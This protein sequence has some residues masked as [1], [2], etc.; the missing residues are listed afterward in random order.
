MHSYIKTFSIT[1]IA[2]PFRFDSIKDKIYMYMSQ[3][4]IEDKDKD[5]FADKIFDVMQFYGKLVGEN[6]NGLLPAFVD[7]LI[8]YFQDLYYSDNA[9]S[10]I[11]I[12]ALSGV[13]SI[14]MRYKYTNS[15]IKK[16]IKLAKK[17]ISLLDNPQKVFLKGG[18][19][20]DIIGVEFVCSSPYEREWVARALYSFFYYQNRTDDHLVYGFYTLKRES[21]YKGLHCD[22]SIFYPR[23]DSR[24]QNTTKADISSFDTSMSHIDIL[25]NYFGL[26][27]IE[28]QIHTSFESLWS[29]MEH[30]YSYNI[31]AKGTGRDEK[32]RTQWKL[33][34]NSIES[35]EMQF[36]RLQVETQ[37]AQYQK[38]P[39]QG[40]KFAKDLLGD[41]DKVAYDRY[42]LYI[43]QI[44]KLET[45]LQNHEIS[46]QEYI[47]KCYQLS[48]EISTLS[49]S[50]TQTDVSF[51]FKMQSVYIY[52]VLAT[53]DE[54]FNTIDI[55]IF[56]KNALDKYI[57][58]HDKL[59]NTPTFKSK[60]LLQIAINLRY[61]QL[62]SKY[63]YGLLK[64]DDKK[65]MA[66]NDYEN[67]MRVFYKLLE[68]LVTLD[69]DSLK[70][71][72]Q[73]SMAFLEISHYTD[74][75]V[76]EF[77]VSNT[78]FDSELDN[79]ILAFRQRYINAD[80]LNYFQILLSKQRIQDIGYIVQVYATMV[81][82]GIMT[83]QDALGDIVRYC[84]YQDV[85]KSDLFVYELASYKFLVVDSCDEIS[86]YRLEHIKDFYIKNMIR[87]LFTI[88]TK[89]SIYKY[90]K[91]KY[92]FE[93]F[94]KIK[95]RLEHCSKV[96]C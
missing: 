69:D 70:L 32:I 65:D 95:F 20:H 96:V 86:S 10:E 14:K 44:H 54:Y 19:L 22:Y 7:A 47:Q 93:Y 83:P 74:V 31:Q 90:N 33:L 12:L 73:D 42:N 82:H 57:W 87:E 78:S 66:L 60:K 40:Y 48:Q 49:D 8:W 35:L 50:I 55:K 9:N 25:R 34:S 58:L 45:L 76:R 77:E 17:D 64:I 24:F 72:K 68:M 23:F 29:S 84:A 52:Y 27:N 11:S 5:I 21:G 43:L 26:F 61:L 4:N 67:N 46:R 75:L 80:L 38:E 59:D 30:K 36:E 91:S 62:A 79:L 3:Q 63:G 1:P 15:V 18:A 85:S 53:H 81:W 16:L 88:Y 2:Y 13:H 39:K 89:E 37:E 6:Q 41:I 51:L 71:L 56:V 28:L 92:I 94:S